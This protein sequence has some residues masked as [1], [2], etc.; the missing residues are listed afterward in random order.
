MG[1]KRK[2]KGLG[3][4]G[5]KVRAGDTA[6]DV[7]SGRMVEVVDAMGGIALV[8]GGGSTDL[9]ECEALTHEDPALTAEVDMGFADLREAVDGLQALVRAKLGEAAS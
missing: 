5:L 6:F 2:R 3:A 7:Y 9:V 8:R 1:K 4:D